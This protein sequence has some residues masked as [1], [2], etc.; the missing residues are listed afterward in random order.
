MAMQTW[1]RQKVIPK[2][3]F[4]APISLNH[5][6]FLIV[7][8]TSI[9]NQ[10]IKYDITSDTYNNWI[11]FPSD[12]AFVAHCIFVWNHSIYV[13]TK[14]ASILTYNLLT[15]QWNKCTKSDVFDFELNGTAYVSTAEYELHIVCGAE[16]NKHFIWTQNN[17]YGR[18]YEFKQFDTFGSL[19]NA[20][21]VHVKSK[22][23]LLLLGG[24][25]HTDWI[26]S[27]AIYS[28][29]ID[30]NEWVEINTTLP[31]AMDSFGYVLTTD[32]KYLLIFGGS[33]EDSR[34]K[35]AIYIMDIETML[36][37]K[38]RL[39]CP[40]KGEYYA[41][42]GFDSLSN[43]TLVNGYIKCCWKLEGFKCLR[44]P[45]DDIVSII[46]S[47]HFDEVIHLFEKTN[48]RHWKIKVDY[49]VNNA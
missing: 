18:K 34:K 8:S 46:Q 32:K 2:L 38:S 44:K 31:V 47:F 30:K 48:G 11:K 5:K 15:N 36:I 41:I 40:E 1:K 4:C 12:Y 20:G 17:S 42:L 33:D 28:Y 9:D 35:D 10:I 24:Y 49:I 23:I 29:D 39:K 37:V 13:F 16:S 43:D 21:L 7:P 22:N 26:C 3:F 25:N 19:S 14:A 45:S 27:D 6:E